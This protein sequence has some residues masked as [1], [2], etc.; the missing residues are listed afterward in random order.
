M[1]YYELDRNFVQVSGSCGPQSARAQF[2]VDAQ[3]VTR[4]QDSGVGRSMSAYSLRADNT[5]GQTAEAVLC[6]MM[7]YELDRNFVQV[8]GSC[9]PQ[10][11]RAQFIVDAQTVTRIQDSGVGVLL[12]QRGK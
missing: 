8:S 12:K 5:N 9:G 3:T 10:S 6:I 1:M 4:I 2:I 7:Y 11:A